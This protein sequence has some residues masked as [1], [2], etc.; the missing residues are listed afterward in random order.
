MY[1]PVQPGTMLYLRT[2]ALDS[3]VWTIVELGYKP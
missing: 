2:Y 1:V 3:L